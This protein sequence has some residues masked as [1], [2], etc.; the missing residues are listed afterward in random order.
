M[1][2]WDNFCICEMKTKLAVPTRGVIIAPICKY[3]EA[4]NVSGEVPFRS[5]W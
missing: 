5:W 4:F 1:V 2:W 3:T